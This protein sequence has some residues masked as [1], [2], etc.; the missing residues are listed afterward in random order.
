MLNKK[1]TAVATNLYTILS[2]M[3]QQFA[4]AYNNPESTDIE[5]TIA[6]DNLADAAMAFMGYEIDEDGDFV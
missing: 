6:Y 4:D 3:C 5:L 1:E 2:A